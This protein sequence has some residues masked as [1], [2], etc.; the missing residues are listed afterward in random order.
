MNTKEQ[1]AFKRKLQMIKRY[2]RKL[3]MYG[4]KERRTPANLGPT[5]SHTTRKTS[6]EPAASPMIP[7]GISLVDPAAWARL[8]QGTTAKAGG[9]GTTVCHSCDQGLLDDGLIR[10]IR[11]LEVLFKPT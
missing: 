9:R 6:A 4:S 11:G 1:G 2:N 10:D 3:W 5:A 8:L 7:S